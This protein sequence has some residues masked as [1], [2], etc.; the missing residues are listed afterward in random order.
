V[1]DLSPPKFK[2]I[3]ESVVG[4]PDPLVSVLYI[5]APAA[6]IVELWNVRGVPKLV[7][8]VVLLDVG[9]TL[10]R[11]APPEVYPVPLD[12]K[13]GEPAPP[14]KLVVPAPKVA[15]LVNNANLNC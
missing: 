8:A 4:V 7:N 13:F 1:D 5:K 15:A 3:T 6:V 2:T 9:V 12:S 11:L 14:A 10:V